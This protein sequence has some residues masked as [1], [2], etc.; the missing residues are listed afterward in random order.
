MKVMDLKVIKWK[1]VGLGLGLIVL[2]VILLSV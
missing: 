2:A 1:Y